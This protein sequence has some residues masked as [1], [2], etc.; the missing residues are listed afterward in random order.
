MPT[1]KKSKVK[2]ILDKIAGEDEPEVI[3]APPPIS[4]PADLANLRAH[5]EH[6][7]RRNDAA[8][9]DITERAGQALR[10]LRQAINDL[11]NLSQVKL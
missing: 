11:E 9:K 2:Q 7:N 3:E 4:D 5:I 8:V 10:D 1:K 6:V